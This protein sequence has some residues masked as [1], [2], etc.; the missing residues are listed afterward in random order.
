M[1]A[2]L[3]DSH[4]V[5]GTGL[6]ADWRHCEQIVRRA[7]LPVFLAGGLSA[8]N[9]AEAIRIVR[10]FGVDV[11]SGVS[12]RIPGGPLVKNMLKCRRFIDAVRRA[13]RELGRE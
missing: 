7:K 4:R 9:V 8:N 6:V 3:L 13:D 11:E 5:G 1:D 10:P 2:Y 12:D